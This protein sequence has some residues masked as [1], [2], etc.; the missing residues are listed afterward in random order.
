[1]CRA[2]ARHPSPRAGCGVPSKGASPRGAQPCRGDPSGKARPPRCSYHHRDGASGSAKGSIRKAQLGH[3]LCIYMAI[4]I[5]IVKVKKIIKNTAARLRVSPPGS[6]ADGTSSGTASIRD[7]SRGA[8]PGRDPQ[9]RGVPA[10]PAGQRP[11]LYFTARVSPSSRSPLVWLRERFRGWRDSVRGRAF[12]LHQV[13][14]LPLQR[15]PPRQHLVLLAADQPARR[16]EVAADGGLEVGKRGV[17]LADALESVSVDAVVRAVGAAGCLAA[18]GGAPGWAPTRRLPT[19]PL[20]PR[21]GVGRSCQLALAAAHGPL[22][23][24]E[25]TDEG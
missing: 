19:S 3:A 18:L 6:T 12:P 1:M 25:G 11:F 17:V 24:R 2:P 15:H 5:T 23:A 4:K 8:G 7:G 20:R 10:L 9:H 22:A 21:R 16:P 13:L 14:H